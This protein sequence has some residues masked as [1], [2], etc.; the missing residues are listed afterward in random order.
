[1]NKKEE[2]MKIS[3]LFLALFMLLTSCGTTVWQL[4]T[5]CNATTEDLFR[6]ISVILMQENFIIKANDPKSG[7]LQAETAPSYNIWLG[8]NEI[9]YWQFQVI[10]NKVVAQA[11]VVNVQQNLFGATTGSSEHYFN[12][13]AHSDW[14]WY[15]NV[16]NELEKLCGHK[17]IFV[18]KK[19]N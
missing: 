9:R 13:D 14:T 15:W 12:D 2:I 6:K 16:R 11:K 4:Q 18:K 1:M 19:V 3:I 8:T 7:Y 5:E 10:D 17:I